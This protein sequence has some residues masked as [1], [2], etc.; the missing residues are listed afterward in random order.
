MLLWAQV[1]QNALVTQL[2]L[3]LQSEDY[4]KAARIRDALQCAA[5]DGEASALLDWHSYDIPKWLCKRAEQ[6]GWRYP[7]GA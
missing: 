7:T 6:L 2:N 3:A 1:D 5:R 4:S